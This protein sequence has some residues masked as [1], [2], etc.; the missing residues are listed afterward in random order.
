VFDF[1]TKF[2]P[3]AGFPQ[4]QKEFNA[5]LSATP[6][7]V[8]AFIRKKGQYKSC[9]AQGIYMFT[10]PEDRTLVYIGKTNTNK[11]GIGGRV[12]RHTR[13]GRSLQKK[14]GISRDTF[15]EYNVRVQPI[16]DASIRGAAE[17]YGI[18]VH[19]P[20]GNLIALKTEGEPDFDPPA[21]TRIT[22]FYTEVVLKVDKD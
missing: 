7:T 16:S 6:F 1:R 4:I 10:D 12:R 18:A 15:L 22:P 19:M 2:L 13:K 20:G 17:L 11:G 21:K 5:L 8:A 3:H 9:T 14:L